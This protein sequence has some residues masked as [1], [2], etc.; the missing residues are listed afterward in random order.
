MGSRGLALMSLR[1]SSFVGQAVAVPLTVMC[2]FT[3]FEYEYAYEYEA[4]DR[5]TPLAHHEDHEGHEA[6]ARWI[7]IGSPVHAHVAVHD[8]S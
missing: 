8:L 5:D 4:A 1:S 3:G 7:A 6:K 2:S